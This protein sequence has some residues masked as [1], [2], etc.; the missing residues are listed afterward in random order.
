MEGKNVYG[1]LQAGILGYFFG[2]IHTFTY[3]WQTSLGD[4]KCIW[5]PQKKLA[6]LFG[7][8]VAESLSEYLTQIVV[9]FLI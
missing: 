5:G 6:L 8:P 7:D 1:F 9:W 2:S 3:S 4:K